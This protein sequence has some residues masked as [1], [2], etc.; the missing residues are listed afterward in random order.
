MRQLAVTATVQHQ[1]HD[2]GLIDLL[3]VLR[4]QH[5]CKTETPLGYL[6]KHNVQTWLVAVAQ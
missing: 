3:D 2:K 1:E 5:A 4:F 6:R